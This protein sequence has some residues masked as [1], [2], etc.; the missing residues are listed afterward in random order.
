MN[1]ITKLQLQKQALEDQLSA[2]R[3]AITECQMYYTSGKFQG[4]NGA[5]AYTQTDV[6]PKLAR[7][8]QIAQSEG[9]ALYWEN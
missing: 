9:G 8:K 2:L 3:N 1:Y 5:Y 6:L 4:I 7:L